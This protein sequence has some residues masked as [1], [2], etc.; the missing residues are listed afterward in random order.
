MERKRKIDTIT[1]AIYYYMVEII[2]QADDLEDIGL[3]K[4]GEELR[5]V[6]DQLER[7][8]IRLLNRQFSGKKHRRR[9]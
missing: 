1:D 6:A 9:A 3:T 7:I 8:G 4:E 5:S 2:S